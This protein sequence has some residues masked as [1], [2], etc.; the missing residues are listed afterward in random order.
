MAI[1]RRL[2]FM[3]TWDSTQYLKFAQERTQPSV[4]LAARV[5]LTSPLTIVDLGCGPG[6]STEVL[7]QRWPQARLTGVDSSREMLAKAR[8]DHPQWLW[9][10]ADIAT[11]TPP[12]PVDLIFANASLQ[13]VADHARLLPRLLNL[14]KPG[15]ALAVQVP[16]HSLRGTHQWM[17]DLARSEGWVKF[18]PG[19]QPRWYGETVGFY[20]DVLASISARLDLWETDYIHV[21]DGPEGVVEWYRG[22]GLRPWLD[23]LTRQ[24]DRARFLMEFEAIVAREFPRRPDGKVLFPFR[25]VF[26]VAY[27]R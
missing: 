16:S 27:R 4:D 8:K 7:A 2:E 12:S 1:A 26:F 24:E 18:F 5:S 22:T 20:Y 6:N 21:L 9:E 25:R 14:V 17:R 10:E 11:W 3:T 19:E 15:G 13:W 23:Q